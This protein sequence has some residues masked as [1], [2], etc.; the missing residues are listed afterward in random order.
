MRHAHRVDFRQDALQMKSLIG[1]KCP[2]EYLCVRLRI[3][4][5]IFGEWIGACQ[6]GQLRSIDLFGDESRDQ[7][8]PL[9][10]R[11][12]SGFA[13][14]QCKPGEL[15]RGGKTLFTA[16]DRVIGEATDHASYLS[17][18]TMTGNFRDPGRCVSIVT[19]KK[20]VAAVA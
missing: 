3:I 2:I 14:T 4:L 11:T 7:P 15:G 16:A 10:M 20:L 12:I 9:Q 18:N 8:P 6:T 13:K 5:R 1:V 19:A 17:R